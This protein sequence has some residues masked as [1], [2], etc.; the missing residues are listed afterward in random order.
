M[1]G[2]YYRLTNPFETGNMTA[3]QHVSKD[4]SPIKSQDIPVIDLALSL[5]GK[6]VRP[7]ICKGA[8]DVP[9][10]I[11][12]ISVI[13]NGV[14]LFNQIITMEPPSYIRYALWARTFQTA[15]NSFRL[16]PRLWSPCAEPSDTSWMRP[17][18]PKKL[19]PVNGVVVVADPVLGIVV[20][21]CRIVS[22]AAA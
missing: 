1:K 20:E 16:R 9:F 19:Q 21:H 8:V 12:D 2:D 5:R 4:K 14:D 15:V 3:W 13:Q 11:E 22:T 18:C 17:T 10:Y 6:L 7:D